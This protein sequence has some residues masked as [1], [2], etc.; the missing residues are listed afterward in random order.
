MQRVYQF[1]HFGEIGMIPA[2]PKPGQ[3]NDAAG[4]MRR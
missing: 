3:V 1:H 2:P 4:T